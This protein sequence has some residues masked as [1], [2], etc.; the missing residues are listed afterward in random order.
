M[1]IIFLTS[2]FHPSVTPVSLIYPIG[3]NFGQARFRVLKKS[4]NLSYPSIFFNI[5]FPFTL[6]VTG[7][8]SSLS[9]KT[10]LYCE[11]QKSLTKW[12]RDVFFFFLSFHRWN[13]EPPQ[14]LFFILVQRRAY[15]EGMG[16]YRMHQPPKYSS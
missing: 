6:C 9:L 11:Q 5:N 1:F 7:V 15:A 8:A 12:V 14:S 4:G 16:G 3:I 2:F 10:F 13:I